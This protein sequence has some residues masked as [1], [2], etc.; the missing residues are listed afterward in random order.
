MQK[1]TL[2]TLRNLKNC[3]LAYADEAIDVSTDT[4]RHSKLGKTETTVIQPFKITTT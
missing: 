4:R 3:K 1:M 2:K